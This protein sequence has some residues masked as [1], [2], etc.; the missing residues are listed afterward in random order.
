VNENKQLVEKFQTFLNEFIL[1]QEVVN[2]VKYELDVLE[3]RVKT[4]HQTTIS[5]DFKTHRANYERK[6]LKYGNKLIELCQNMLF[7]KHDVP[8]YT[9]RSEKFNQASIKQRND[10]SKLSDDMEK[11]ADDINKY[12]HEIKNN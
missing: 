6:Q 7:I 5:Q 11:L 2:L 10:L 8:K 12:V 1:L 3:L 4:E 9:D